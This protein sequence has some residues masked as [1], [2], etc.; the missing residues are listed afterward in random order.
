MPTRTTGPERAGDSS[1]EDNARSSA[2]RAADG[3]LLACDAGGERRLDQGKYGFER[4]TGS[5]AG[6]AT[7][8]LGAGAIGGGGVTIAAVDL[9]AGA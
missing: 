7:G 6:G 2:D 3:G 5:P 4:S 8:A 9:A 1:R